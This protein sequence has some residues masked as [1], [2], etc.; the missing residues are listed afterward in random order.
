M[1][2]QPGRYAGKISAACTG[3]LAGKRA[4]T[5]ICDYAG[6]RAPTGIGGCVVGAS[7]L[8]K[9]SVRAAKMLC[10]CQRIAGKRAPTVICDYAG[11]RSYGDWRLCCG[12]EFAREE[13]GTDDENVVLV[14][15]HRGQARS[16]SDLRLRGQARSYSDLRLR[17]QARL[18]G[19]AVV[20]WERACSRRGR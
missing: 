4:P 2:D 14:P 1:Q 8:A 18:R 12:S 15:T 9:R 17:G 3:P 10:L 5:V 19:L 16:Y 11:K 7:L 20:L 13:A 6:K